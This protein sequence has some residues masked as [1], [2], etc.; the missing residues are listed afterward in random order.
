MNDRDR[1]IKLLMVGGFILIMI[2]N[3]EMA[4]ENILAILGLTFLM[5]VLGIG[6]L[7]DWKKQQRGEETEQDEHIENL[8]W[9]QAA[10]IFCLAVMVFYYL[11]RGLGYGE[12]ANSLLLCTLILFALKIVL[13]IYYERKK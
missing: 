11:L 2:L 8:S 13:E 9:A 7:R 3:G 10:R 12:F 4:G 1:G 5:I 6:S